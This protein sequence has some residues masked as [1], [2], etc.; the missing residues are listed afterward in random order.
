VGNRVR[1][2]FSIGRG[3]FLASYKQ[4]VDVDG[5]AGRK[6]VKFLLTRCRKS[7]GHEATPLGA[8]NNPATNR[9]IYGRVRPRHDVYAYEPVSE[10]D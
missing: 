1:Y 7:L 10:P 9:A 2:R 8:Q 3:A 4:G 6:A 5:L